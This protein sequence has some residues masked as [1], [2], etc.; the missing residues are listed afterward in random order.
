[1][2]LIYEEINLRERKYQQPNEATLETVHI[3]LTH[4]HFFMHWKK[5]VVILISLNQL[6]MHYEI[7]MLCVSVI[8]SIQFGSVHIDIVEFTFIYTLNLRWTHFDFNFVT[9][10]SQQVQLIYTHSALKFL[11]CKIFSFFVLTL[12]SNTR[13]KYQFFVRKIGATFICDVF[14]HFIHT[15]TSFSIRTLCLQSLLRLWLVHISPL[16]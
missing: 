2:C 6:K 1:M 3:L 4:V 16:K 13:R 11:A 15:L 5:F 14:I 9:L 8:D 12:S 7:S 10:F